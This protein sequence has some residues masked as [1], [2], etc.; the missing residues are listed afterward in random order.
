[1]IREFNLNAKRRI[2]TF[3]VNYDVRAFE[4]TIIINSEVHEK[5][6]GISTTEEIV[7]ASGLKPITGLF[8]SE[9]C[10]EYDF[11]KMKYCYVLVSNEEM[12]KYLNEIRY[13]PEIIKNPYS[14]MLSDPNW[15]DKYQVYKYYFE[16]KIFQKLNGKFVPFRIYVDSYI[17]K[18]FDIYGEEATLKKLRKF[19]R[20]K[21]AHYDSCFDTLAFTYTPTEDEFQEILKAEGHLSLEKKL[22]NYLG[23]WK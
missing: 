10:M 2:N 17:M 3:E 14:V 7:I 1:M 8:G 22:V 4:D 6:E 5:S 23:L 12:Q 19:E 16:N 9:K 11:L 20:A 21:R 15:K 13:Q 18:E